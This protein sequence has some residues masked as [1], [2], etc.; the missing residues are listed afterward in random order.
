MLECHRRAVS[1]FFRDL[2]GFTAFSEISEP[3][4]VMMVLREYHTTLG[5]LIDKFEGTVGRS[6]GDGVL[7]LFND[8]RFEPGRPG[9]RHGPAQRLTAPDSGRGTGEGSPA[10]RRAEAPA[11]AG[12]AAVIHAL[13]QEP[14]SLI[15]SLGPA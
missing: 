4:E 9:S 10:S 15:A 14:Q 13:T 8:P 5:A 11:A 7:V 6:T 2:R 1:V 12:G 3:E